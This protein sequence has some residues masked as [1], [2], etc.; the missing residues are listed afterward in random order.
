MRKILRSI[1]AL[2][3]AR[4]SHGLRPGW[5]GTA[6]RGGLGH[7]R[8]QSQVH[9]V[10][11]RGVIFNVGQSAAPGGSVAAVRP[12]ELHAIDELRDGVSSGG[13]RARSRRLGAPR[14]RHSGD[15]RGAARP[16]G[17]AAIMPGTLPVQRRPR[18][19][20][21]SSTDNSSSGPPRTASSR[22]P[23]PTTRWSRAGRSRLSCPGASR[24]GPGWVTRILST[25][26]RL[27]S[28]TPWWAICRSR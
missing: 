7:G 5:P 25:R 18:S 23:W 14:W 20:C 13:S 28:R 17:P 26:S 15:G 6:G 2:V 8:C 10:H 21:P 22:R 16:R 12:Q 19:P 11:G 9:R 4:S 1:I 27:C 3:V 24:P